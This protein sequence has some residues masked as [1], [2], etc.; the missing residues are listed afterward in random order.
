MTDD[1]RPGPRVAPGKPEPPAHLPGPAQHAT[2]SDGTALANARTSGATEP[3]DLLFLAD[4]R[5]RDVRLAGSKAAHLARAAH[6]GLPV[7]PGFVLLDGAAVGVEHGPVHDAWHALSDGGRRPLVVRSS[8]P[9]EDTRESSL[10]GQFASVLDVRGWAAFRTAVATVR[11]SAHRG[12]PVQPGQ[13][14]PHPAGP[15]P[16]GPHPAEPR[17]GKPRPGGPGADPC[18]HAPGA[19]DGAPVGRAARH[20]P[21][22]MAVLVQPMVSARLGG[23]LF[24]A[25]PL[26]G[27]ADTLLVSVV[28]G[29]PDALVGGTR[30]GTTY[31]LSRHGRPRREDGT[32]GRARPEAKRVTG[33]RGAGD[34]S[35]GAGCHPSEGGG[36]RAGAGEAPGVSGGGAPGSSGAGPSGGGTRAASHGGG[37]A[38]PRDDGGRGP[39][40]L[41]GQ[42]GQDG[43]DEGAAWL[44]GRQARRLAGLA[45]RGRR[46]F[47]GAQDMEFG[48]DAEGRLW[49]FQSRPITALAP[50]PE[51]RARLLGPG[52]VAET[53]PE[54]LQPLE[55]DLWVTPMARG[56]AAALDIGAAAPRRRLRALPVVR[57][58]GGRAVADL[59][60][61]GVAGRPRHRLV[62]A[63]NPLPGARRLGAAWRLGRLRGELPGLSRDLLADVDRQLTET[64]PPATL[65]HAEI[66]ALLRWGRS[67]LV[68]LHAQE[69]LAGALLASGPGEPVAGGRGGGASGTYGAGDTARTDGAERADDATGARGGG[70]AGIGRLG[71]R[72]AFVR[73]PVAGQH[74]TGDAPLS[75]DGP[76]GRDGPGEAGRAG[77]AAGRALGALREG[78]ARGLS[79][80]RIIAGSPLVLALVPPRLAAPTRLPELP[81]ASG[82]HPGGAGWSAP[83][84]AAAPRGGGPPAAVAAT[85][86]PREGLRLRVRWVHELQVRL[87]REVAARLVARGALREPDRVALLRWRE[88]ASALAGGPLPADLA[89]RLPRP[90]SAP[91]PDAFRLTADGVAVPEAVA[92]AA[93]RT[94]GAGGGGQG[95]SVG[96]A[97][98]TAWD[99]TGPRPASAV[100]VTRTLDPA[101]APLLPELS[102]LLAQTGGPLSHLALLARESRLPAVVGVA[103]AVRR[104]PPGSGVVLDGATGAVGHAP[105]AEPR[106][107]PS[108]RPAAPDRS[109]PPAGTGA[110]PAG[111]PGPG[112]RDAGRDRPAGPGREGACDR[113]GRDGRTGAGGDTGPGDRRGPADGTPTERHV[114]RGK[115]VD[116]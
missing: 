29:G 83:S 37:G 43:Q 76:D 68:A 56:L 72:G 36:T 109:P 30:S 69:A 59:E 93:G 44:T 54:T 57:A 20:G 107:S 42:D 31:R 45:R 99:G 116:G 3:P 1:D 35:S 24:G 15:R 4:P 38:A 27:R 21:A 79:D 108:D 100:L 87:V 14:E 80:A 28:R 98:G 111:A 92:Y 102:G 77:T 49:L 46:V 58:V 40:G 88:L 16:T 18:A 91:L 90:P 8:S 70:G 113:S 23:V 71:V 48:F 13:H 73:R 22:P 78:R 95:V 112:D 25:D 50:T 2:P 34:R 115:E 63:L 96:R 61:L 53:L 26:T 86:A 47:G 114:G 11:A 105:P 97:H 55:E 19:G 6:A 10:A 104:F 60:L 17:R 41:D 12:H 64:P 62:A 9:R 81:H 84:E 7:L 106:S 82:G 94:P 52:P 67:A 75:G 110:P 101:L 74:A 33:A 89:E 65:R 85:L 39:S 103:D 66:L 5:A 32:R 51:R